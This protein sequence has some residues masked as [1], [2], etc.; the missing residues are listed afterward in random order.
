M[1]FM[2][3]RWSAVQRGGRRM[4]CHCSHAALR[5]AERTT[6]LLL[7]VIGVGLL[8]IISTHAYRHGADRQCVTPVS[9]GALELSMH[10]GC[11]S[12]FQILGLCVCVCVSIVHMCCSHVHP[13]NYPM[14][15]TCWLPDTLAVGQGHLLPR[16]C[17]CTVGPFLVLIGTRGHLTMK[18]A[19]HLQLQH[20]VTQSASKSQ[21]A[22]RLWSAMVCLLTCMLAH[23]NCF[24]QLV[25]RL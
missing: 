24:V 20:S 18:C 17:W 8:P 22:Y 10:D 2:L 14:Q 16:I 11:A 5:Y 15:T 9:L 25:S 7:R 12:I 23:H 3:D 19:T 1:Y 6:L 13:C 21:Q 4:L